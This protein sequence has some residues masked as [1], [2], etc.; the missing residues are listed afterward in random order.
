[1]TRAG[2]AN[3]AGAGAGAVAVARARA[4]AGAGAGAGTAIGTGTAWT[5]TATT[6]RTGRSVVRTRAVRMMTWS[7]MA[8]W[9]IMMSCQLVAV[10]GHDCLG[11]RREL[12]GSE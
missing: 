8:G 2:D 10:R 5:G 7:R 6:R 9:V 4:R 3:G 11:G 12:G 1:M